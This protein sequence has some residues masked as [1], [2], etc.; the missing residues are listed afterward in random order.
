MRGGCCA[1]AFNG[2]CA[3]TCPNPN[4]QHAPP[5]SGAPRA[6]QQAGAAARVYFA[7]SLRFATRLS[8]PAQGYGPVRQKG[9][10]LPTRCY[11]SVHAESWSLHT[12]ANVEPLMWNQSDGARVLHEDG[13][14]QRARMPASSADLAWPHIFAFLL[15]L[16]CSCLAKE[17]LAARRNRRR[18]AARPCQKLN[19]PSWPADVTTN[20]PTT[21]EIPSQRRYVCRYVSMC[22]PRFTTGI[23]GVVGSS[24]VAVGL[25]LAPNKWQCCAPGTCSVGQNAARP[26]KKTPAP[27]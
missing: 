10:V 24:H 2:A 27:H 13:H 11:L 23:H 19:P 22:G 25:G 8:K 16:P 5:V 6:A 1:T 3:H 14:R 9:A 26:A 17:A 7:I 18:G 15:S 4:Q 12:Q 21:N 20:K